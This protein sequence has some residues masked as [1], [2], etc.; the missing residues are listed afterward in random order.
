MKLLPLLFACLLSFASNA[1]NQTDYAQQ[2]KQKVTA[3]KKQQRLSLGSVWRDTTTRF[4]NPSFFLV[5][6]EPGVHRL[7]QDNMPCIVPD[8]SAT[9]SI[10]NAWQDE[11]K[12]PYTSPAARI[13]NAA[14]SWPPLQA[15]PPD[16]K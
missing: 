2:F 8:P 7:R 9:V 12:V 16:A 15:T 10:P 4:S 5:N 1:Q 14:Q 11:V 3:L 13:P 6:P